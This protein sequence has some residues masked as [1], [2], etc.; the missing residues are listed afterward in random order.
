MKKPLKRF[1]VMVALSGD[2]TK[3]VRARTES[4]AIRKAKALVV[5]KPMK[6]K[7]IDKDNTVAESE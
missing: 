7:F 3:I 5:G 1:R 2:I 6:R 4:E